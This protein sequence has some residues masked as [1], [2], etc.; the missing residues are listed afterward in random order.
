MVAP[1]ARKH[2]VRSR[3]SR[4]CRVRR[5]GSL[6]WAISLG[7]LRDCERDSSKIS[8][9]NYEKTRSGMA[10]LFLR[11]TR[12]LAAIVHEEARRKA[13]ALRSVAR[14]RAF[15]YGVARRWRLPGRWAIA[16]ARHCG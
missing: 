2:G 12:G 13:Q 16:P 1:S 3:S 10:N 5:E 4:R 6:L 9:R 14:C 11:A 8:H 15:F 7:R